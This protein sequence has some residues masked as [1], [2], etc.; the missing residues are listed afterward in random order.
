MTGAVASQMLS[1]LA[2]AHEQGIIHRDLKPANVMLVKDADPGKPQTIK[3]LDFG[4]AKMVAAPGCGPEQG[5]GQGQG[6]DEPLTRGL[7][8]FGTPSYMSPEQAA[9]EEVDGN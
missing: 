8:I 7:M 6:N 4:I 3:I 2:H 9:G 1:A 5:Q